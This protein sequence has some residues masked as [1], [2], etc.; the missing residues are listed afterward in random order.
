MQAGGGACPFRFRCVGCGHFRSD[1][2]YLPELRGYLELLLRNRERVRA[3]V[4][5]E[6]WARAE[7]MPSEEE[8]G[9][10]RALI[11][12]VETDLEQLSDDDRAQID[13]ACQVVR[14]TRQT[15][16]LGMPT[17]GPPD[18]DPALAGSG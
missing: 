9:R 16:H 14:A 2:S 17:I 5:L 8:I 6:D 4:E 7:A 13:A 12:R 3:A 15:V 18:P 10:V 11:R 1:P